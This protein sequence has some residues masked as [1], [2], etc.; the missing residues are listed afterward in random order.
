M[1]LIGNAGAQAAVGATF[2]QFLLFYD[3]FATVFRPFRD[4]LPS[5][6]GLFWRTA[7]V[8]GIAL[9]CF[10]T[11]LLKDFCF[12]EFFLNGVSQE[13]VVV[14]FL[15]DSRRTSRSFPRCDFFTL[16]IVNFHSKNDEFHSKND[17]FFYSKSR[18]PSGSLWKHSSWR[19][20][21]QSLVL[22]QK[23]RFF[24]RKWRFF[25]RKWSH[26]HPPTRLRMGMRPNWEV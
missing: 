24:N 2:H 20:C 23:R 10:R 7:T 13:F 21:C 25:D 26:K 9:V 12:E 4:W 6:L 5:N 22:V 11:V 19:R 8:R 1:N 3:R 17:C 18:R 16:E 14:L 15:G